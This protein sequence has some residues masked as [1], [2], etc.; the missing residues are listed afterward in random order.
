MADF[1]PDQIRAAIINSGGSV[2]AAA[3]SLGMSRYAL[4]RLMKAQ[5][6]DADLIRA[7]LAMGIS[8]P[9]EGGGAV[10]QKKIVEVVK[11]VPPADYVALETKVRR[12]QDQHARRERDW[13]EMSRQA[14]IGDRIMDAIAPRL[15]EIQIPTVRKPKIAT[16]DRSPVTLMAP[17]SDIH[18][19]KVFFEAQTGGLNAYGPE[20]AARR[21]Q[22]VVDVIGAW[23]K[24]YEA[25]GRPVE[26][27]VVPMI[28]DNFNGNLHPE[29][30]D[31]YADSL[32]QCIDVSLVLAQMIAE[33]AHWF[34]RID[35]VAPAGDNH[36]RLTK[37]SATSAKAFGTTLNTVMMTSIAMLLRGIKHVKVHMDISHQTYFNI[38]GKTYGACHGNMLKGGGG[39]LG[40]PAYG[41]R[42][43]H[44]GSIA[45]TVILAKR[46]AR[47]LKFEKDTPLEERLSRMYSILEGIVD[48]SLVGHFHTRQVLEFTTGALYLLPSAMGPDPYARDALRKPGS[49][50]RQM[51]FAIHPKLDIIGEH[52]IRLNQ[53]MDHSATSRYKWG[54]IDNGGDAAS[55]MNEWEDLQ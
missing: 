48:F 10:E 40:I 9:E 33:M 37:K 27:L 19:G 8:A 2:K 26:R 41:M 35:I 7:E 49:M 11:E 36:T 32:V 44:D 54:V 24:N 42:R 16:G 46:H 23:K 20:I 55:L 1:H 29:D 6:I 50:A 47:E 18:W 17:L 21:L 22:H 28:G 3:S 53:F 15:Q 30:E 13:K 45:E 12:L 34:P 43:H 4:Y 5:R 14:N 51:L 39:S 31:N 38:Y 25:Q 52:E